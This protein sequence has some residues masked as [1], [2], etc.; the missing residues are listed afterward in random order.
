MPEGAGVPLKIRCI[1]TFIAIAVAVLAWPLAAAAQESAKVPRIGFLSGLSPAVSAVWHEA[2]RQ[3]LRDLGWVEQ[4]NVGIEY[5]Y[6]DG[7][8]DRLAELAADLVRLKVDVIVTAVTL[9][10][11]AAKNAT[12][13][14]PIV[15]ASPGDPVATGLVGSLARPGGNVT[16]LSQVAPDLAGKRLELLKEIVPRL[17]RVAVLWNPGGPA[18]ALSWNEIQAPARQLGVRLH[19]VE[20]RSPGDFDKAFEDAAKTRAGAVVIIGHAVFV[21][22]LKRI[23]DLA[24]KSRL[25]SIFHLR[26][27]VDAGGLM[28]YG[29]DRSDMF[30]RAAIYVDKI[31]KG[32]KPGDLPIEQPTKF[33]LALN[34]K[35]ARALGLTVPQALL[36]RADHVVQ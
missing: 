15:M 11:Q 21:T 10:A 26:E 12:R 32:A 1:S 7:R 29:P 30:R 35:T 17:S 13:S 18:S 4:K 24:A 22:N 33:E 34:L 25:A 31:L 27:F 36:L 5:R 8:S 28:A 23:A 2:F 20:V 14:I 9:D 16:G 19:S 3:S 6:A